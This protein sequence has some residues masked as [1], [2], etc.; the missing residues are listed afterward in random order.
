MH[1]ALHAKRRAKRRKKPNAGREGAIVAPEKWEKGKRDTKP[2]PIHAVLWVSDK[3]LLGHRFQKSE[4]ET[5][6][7][8]TVPSAH[9]EPWIRPVVIVETHRLDKIAVGTFLPRPE[10]ACIIL[11]SAAVSPSAASLIGC[12]GNGH[13]KRA[14]GK[15]LP[16]QDLPGSLF[17]VRSFFSSSSS[18]VM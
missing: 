3:S 15:T 10:T 11:I 13:N 4:R 14:A 2:F 1:A 9:L 16:A 17:G 7:F 12:V 6:F 18:G 5:H 8:L